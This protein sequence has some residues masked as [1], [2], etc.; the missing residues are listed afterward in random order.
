MESGMRRDLEQE[1]EKMVSVEVSSKVL[2][3][4]RDPEQEE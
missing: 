3:M 1:V 4:R 2:V